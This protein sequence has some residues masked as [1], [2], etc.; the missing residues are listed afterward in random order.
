MDAAQSNPTPL[1]AENQNCGVEAAV[2]HDGACSAAPIA[3][4]EKSST[5]AI[6]DQKVE[7]SHPSA[8]LMTENSV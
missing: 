7:P 2:S 5:S 6:A 1:L 3:K 4:N 8:E